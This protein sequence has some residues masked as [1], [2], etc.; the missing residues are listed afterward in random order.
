MIISQT[1]D[2]PVSD[3]LSLQPMKIKNIKYCSNSLN[4]NWWW[5]LFKFQSLVN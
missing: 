2:K 3:A 5:Q 4:Q 1:L